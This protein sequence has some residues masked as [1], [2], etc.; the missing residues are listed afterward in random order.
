MSI[1]LYCLLF[2]FQNKK[3][4]DNMK[5][6]PLANLKNTTGIVSF[7]KEV[8]EIVVANRNGQPKLVLMSREVYENGFGK[9]TGDVYFNVKRDMELLAEP[10]LFNNPAE[11]VRICDK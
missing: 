11:I 8:N 10:V 6:I 4:V 9:V 3:G 2:I 7:C 5:Y 1:S